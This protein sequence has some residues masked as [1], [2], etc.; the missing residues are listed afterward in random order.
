MTGIEF[1][2]AAYLFCG[3]VLVLFATFLMALRRGY[4]WRR[5]GRQSAAIR[6]QIREALVDCLA[7]NH[8]LTRLKGFV[9]T[10]EADVGE[11]LMGFQGTVGGD[12]VSAW[13]SI[14]I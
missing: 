3:Y 11:T 7:G 4:S 6:P 5:L 9:R 10:N 14:G 8:D 13:A 12:L 2:V 1:R